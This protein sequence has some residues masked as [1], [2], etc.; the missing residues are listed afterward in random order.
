MRA[1]VIND[2]PII[3]T[4]CTASLMPK[5]SGWNTN[6]ASEFQ[7]MAALHRLGFDANLTLGN[8]KAVDIVV[9]RSAGDAVTIDVKAVA[10]KV[11]WLVGTAGGAPR[12]RHFVVL[13]SYDGAFDDPGLPP[14]RAWV[15]PHA[16]FLALV[17]QAHAPSTLRFVSRKAVVETCAHRLGAW[18]LLAQDAVTPEPPAARA[19]R[20][21][22]PVLP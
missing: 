16:E 6:L 3:A 22:R 17:K 10:G 15:L 12:P 19:R 4:T 2:A 14:P 7:V 18:G 5:K 9:V 13:L 20:V 8:K 1:Y 11:D 21:R